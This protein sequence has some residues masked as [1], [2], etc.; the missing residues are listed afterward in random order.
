M[1]S[2]CWSLAVVVVSSAC[3][4]AGEQRSSVD[5]S[6]DNAEGAPVVASPDASTRSE[7][8]SLDSLLAVSRAVYQEGEFEQARALYGELRERA[9]A[10][11]NV[12]IE[13]RALTSMG[14]A[15]YNLGDY[16]LSRTL[17]EEALALKLRADLTDAYARSYN[18]LGLLA[19]QENRYS[20]ARLLFGRTRESASA[21]GD[22]LGAAAAAG[23]LALVQIDLG[24]FDRAREN[25]WRHREVGRVASGS[26][27]PDQARRGR[28]SVGNS[29]TNLGMLEIR[30]GDPVAA[31][32]LLD[33]ALAVYEEIGDLRGATAALGQLGA[34]YT[35]LGEL[36][37][38]FEVLDSALVLA[39]AQGVQQEEA[40]LYEAMAEIY[41]EAGDFRRT[42]DLY[43][44]AGVI[45]RELGLN[46]ETGVSFRGEAGVQARLGDLDRAE[47]KA[48]EALAIHV[49]VGAPV[50]EMR[51]RLM[52]AEI[53][54]RLDRPDDARRQIAEAQRLADRLSGRLW[55]L[56]VALTEARIADAKGRSQDVLRAID[57]ID[58][59][60]DRGGYSAE[61][62][63]RLLASK[64]H[65]R[66]NRLE[67]A[68]TEGRAAWAAVERVRT[69]FASGVL[70][71]TFMADKHGVYAHLVTL[72]LR[73]GQEAEAFQVADAARGRALAESLSNRDARGTADRPDGSAHGGGVRLLDEIDQLLETVEDL[74][75]IPGRDRSPAEVREIELF[76]ERVAE[77]RAEYERH[78]VQSA[79]A[80]SVSVL[81]GASLDVGAVQRSL[82]T[83]QALLEYFVP[84]EGNVVIFVL[85]SD[86]LHV[87][88]SP[89]AASNLYSRVRLARDLI[90]DP[91]A[92]NL[93]TSGVLTGLHDGLI[94]PV[95][96]RG[97]LDGVKELVVIPHDILTYLP[98]AALRDRSTSRYLMETV[99]LRVLPTAAAI[100]EL[101]RRAPASRAGG[102]SG[103]APFPRELRHSVAEIA[104]LVGPAPVRRFEG[105]GA[106]EAELR[107]GLVSDRFV[108]IA[109]HGVLNPRNPMFSR[110]EMAPAADGEDGDG[111]LEVH[112]LLDLDVRARLVFISGCETAL[113]PAGST[114]FDQGEDYATLSLALLHAGAR[115]VIATLWRVEDEGAAIFAERFFEAL[116]ASDPADA[117][118]QAQR[119]MLVESRYAAPYY[120]GAYQLAGWAG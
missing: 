16:E 20:D 17:G 89:L 120:W 94:R 117:L 81:G 59:D 82:R 55:Q 56:E 13:A 107:R 36:G 77:A 11:A 24:Q 112:E 98:F 6:P 116:S 54:D 57:R 45:N 95:L 115:N 1:Q 80:G 64:A 62:Q 99:S 90:A 7:L 46:L 84:D 74:E 12:R 113:G 4:V 28:V 114:S 73:A 33:S 15:S 97:L 85:T 110:L 38:A 19:W 60:L 96:N 72:L 47:A 61:W 5:G 23:N 66:E 22:D 21:V 14:L 49:E 68:L 43:E 44:K 25:F 10:D 26:V 35:A 79:G 30:V 3:G 105:A 118:V 32:Q 50:E 70:R 93:R 67:A 71:T 101:A 8:V 92:Q 42:F 52:L 27:D 53:R 41:L 37:R 39:R 91:A 31:L 65:A 69:S 104:A 40:S 9:R 119:A 2:C 86:E 51:D 63:A 100:P 106:T 76:Y 58:D 34:A 108:H 83:G 29:F 88:E 109:T 102:T 111:R 103:F 48:E 78:V 18:A 87:L 75:E